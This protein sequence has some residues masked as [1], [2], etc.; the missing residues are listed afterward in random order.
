MPGAVQS[1]IDRHWAEVLAEA[2]AWRPG[3]S[4]KDA[5]LAYVQALYREWEAIPLEEK[6]IPYVPF[7]SHF[8]AVLTALHLCAVGR[9]RIH[10]ERPIPED[11]DS[12]L[13]E[14]LTEAVQYMRTKEP[15]PKNYVARRHLP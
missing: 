8:W 6:Q 2:E 9:E 7:E 5:A 14:W 15:L 1:Y 10:S 11:F 3:T 12:Q 13:A 4:D